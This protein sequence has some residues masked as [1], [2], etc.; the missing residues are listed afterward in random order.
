M[1]RLCIDFDN[2]EKA[3]ALYEQLA[4]DETRHADLIEWHIDTLTFYTVGYF[5]KGVRV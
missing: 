1:R 3:N 2:E 5:T 4:Q